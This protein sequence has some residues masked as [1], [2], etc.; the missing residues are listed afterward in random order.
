MGRWPDESR[1]TL[2]T[3]ALIFILFP[4]LCALAWWFVEG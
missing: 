3:A 4:L 2:T 1:S